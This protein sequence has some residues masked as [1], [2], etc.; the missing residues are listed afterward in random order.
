MD[1]VLTMT[2][3][4][5]AVC[6]SVALS[7]ASAASVAATPDDLILEGVIVAGNPARSIAL[8]RASDAERARPL[9]IGQEYRGYVLQEVTRE[10]VV[11][12]GPDGVMRVALGRMARAVG[13]PDDGGRKGPEATWVLHSFPRARTRARLE[14]EIPA[15]LSDTELVPHVED[16]EVRGLELRRLPDGTLL[17]ESGLF[18][19][20]VLKSVNGEPIRSM[21][22]FWTALSR[23]RG[24]EQIRLVVERGGEVLRL[25][26]AFSN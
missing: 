26:Y 16:G 4:A 12:E 19:G 2:R 10:G 3:L 25:A 11:L 18:P 17:S 8:L 6:V 15:I 20:D 21:E 1:R 14:K 23:L 9:R 5:V 22:A 24:R 13:V 7:Y